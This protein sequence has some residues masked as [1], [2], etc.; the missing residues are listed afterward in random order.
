MT[1]LENP[2]KNE[3][4]LKDSEEI[5]WKEEFTGSMESGSKIYSKIDKISKPL[6]WALFVIFTLVAVGIGFYFY[7]YFL[8]RDIAF[9]LSAPQSVL[10]GVPFDIETGTKIISIMRLTM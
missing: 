6:F 3:I 5:G 2:N 4:N 10:A 1:S 8:N 9:S 7:S